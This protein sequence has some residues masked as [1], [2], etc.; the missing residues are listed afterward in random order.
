MLTNTLIMK[1]IQ[2]FVM[3]L[4][5][6][7]AVCSCTQLEVVLPRGP[8]GEQGI[9]GCD[10]LSAY[11]VWIQSIKNRI[12]SYAG[13]T[14]I[15]DFFIYLKGKD[16]K[17]GQKG[18]DG[19]DGKDGLTPFIGEDGN[20]HLGDLN[21]GVPARGKDGLIPQVAD[22]KDGIPQWIFVRGQNDTL[23]LGVPALGKDGKD[24]LSAYEIWVK[25][26][27]AGLDDPKRPGQRW[28]MDKTTVAD[29]YDFLSGADGDNGL[30]PY[31]GGNGNWFIGETD[32]GVPAQGVDG[33]SAYE[34]WKEV[35]S[36]G[37]LDDPKS[38]DPSVLW[39]ADKVTEPDFFEYLTGV[40]GQTPTIGTNGNWFIGT[41][42]TGIPAQGPD[43]AEGLSAYEL[44]VADVTG[45][46]GL[47]NPKAPG[48][49]W[50]PAKTTLADF[51]DYLHGADGMDGADGQTAY[52]LWK[53]MVLSPEGLPNPENGVYDVTEYPNW[54]ATAVAETDFWL[55]LKGKDGVDETA[56]PAS[57]S[58]TLQ[59]TVYLERVDPAKYN[60]AP[61]I[62]L[63]KTVNGKTT[64][65]YVNPWSG[66]A[67]FIVTGPGPVIVPN[68]T[69]TF[70][71]MKGNAYTK[72]S[73]AAGYIYLPR[74]ELPVY[75]LGDP[76]ALDNPDDIHNGTRPSSFS[77]GT[78]TVTDPARIASTTK[79]PYQVD[80][81]T[82]LTGAKLISESSY[83]G[84]TV[85]RVIEGVTEEVN[86]ISTDA[87]MTASYNNNVFKYYRNK[88]AAILL[89]RLLEN[90]GAN[91]NTYG[92]GSNAMNVEDWMQD[93]TAY[94]A[95]DHPSICTRRGAATTFA[96]AQFGDEVTFI[97]GTATVAASRGNPEIVKVDETFIGSG[98]HVTD[99][100]ADYGTT[101]SS[102]KE[103]QVPLIAQLPEKFTIHS[104]Y[105]WLS[106]HTT[107]YFEL[108]QT[109]WP[110]TICYYKRYASL[111]GDRYVFESGTL[112]EAMRGQNVFVKFSGIFNGSQINTE[113][114]LEQGFKITITD[115]YDDFYFNLDVRWSSGN[116]VFV[117]GF[118]GKLYY[119]VG[120]D[121][122]ELMGVEIRANYTG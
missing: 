17:D 22:G 57:G 28:P 78:T 102:V 117:E 20:W 11:E 47:P 23:W 96:T 33:K 60:V 12:I 35:A 9:P 87:N 63:S 85:K 4:L 97:Q 89:Q 92:D 40:D 58:L 103:Y 119:T 76:S 6:G 52:E 48:T 93:L 24:G 31:I 55:Y 90:G 18:E 70:T 38:D 51:Y 122:A 114:L 111:E 49:N 109:D 81:V 121:K 100:L 67:A 120:A 42:D 46:D 80:L 106:G 45:I 64:Y 112:A 66:S 98:R 25:S 116:P 29:F 69:V 75:S 71:D 82:E 3:A 37:T 50:D 16:G 15:N 39:P 101:A 88:G 118:G 77:F 73:D 10:G 86:F 2:K 61:V 115:V 36:T 83:A 1:K 84:Y 62:T 79:V 5:A 30:I 7:M 53:S 105:S 65:E 43:G 95:N 41:T 94:T 59:D 104:L 56:E 19:K 107:L 54:P 14:E 26:V 68:C 44:W 8:Q 113:R 21:T 72:T 91:S 108:D 27:A 74:K 13:G 32:T 99:I 34:I 110:T